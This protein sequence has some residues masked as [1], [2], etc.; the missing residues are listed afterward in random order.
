M[1][2]LAKS[3]PPS[4]GGRPLKP[5]TAEQVKKI[6][7]IMSDLQAELITRDQANRRIARID[8]RWA[9][10]P[11]TGRGAPPSLRNGAAKDA[12]ISRDQL[13]QAIRVANVPKGDFFR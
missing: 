12:G 4:K 11:E 9:D 6:D 7:K 3:I 1:G 10:R 5:R 13:K 2:D 8:P